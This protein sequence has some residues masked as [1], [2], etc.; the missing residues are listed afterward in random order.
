MT[1]PKTQVQLA[2][3]ACERLVRARDKVTDAISHLDCVYDDD[4][5]DVD[6]GVIRQ[7]LAANLKLIN[8]ALKRRGYVRP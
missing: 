1:P 8:E 4:A 7:M 6:E 3:E 5:I 2:K